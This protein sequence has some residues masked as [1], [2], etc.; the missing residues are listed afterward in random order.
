MLRHVITR[1]CAQLTPAMVSAQPAFAAATGGVSVKALADLKCVRG[2]AADAGEDEGKQFGTCKWFNT[3]KGWG[4]IAPK[5]GS[6][7]VFVHQVPFVGFA[8]KSLTPCGS[9]QQCP[10]PPL[11]PPCSGFRNKTFTCVL[12]VSTLYL[13][14]H[15]HR[16]G[17]EP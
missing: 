11:L 9:S 15:A 13:A 16:A 7:D 1:A 3:T 17:L 10:Q 6:A 14:L 8:G 5:D 2:F 12:F 4:F